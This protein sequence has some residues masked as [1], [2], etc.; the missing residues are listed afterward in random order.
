MKRN[1]FKA[2]FYP[3]KIFTSLTMKVKIFHNLYPKSRGNILP[4]AMK[5]RKHQ[6]QNL[7]IFMSIEWGK[8]TP[9][10]MKVSIWHNQCPKSEGNILLLAMKVRKRQSQNLALFMSI[11]WRKHAPSNM[12]LRIWHNQCPKSEGNIPLLA[13]NFRRLLSQ[14]LGLF[15]SIQGGNILLQL[16]KS[17]SGTINVQKVRETYRLS[18]IRRS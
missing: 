17:E 9:S 13:M 2:G 3:P 7:A 5:F 12:K 1:D 10:A 8:H 14:N 16:W 6:S 4:L 15:M 18:Y 11:E